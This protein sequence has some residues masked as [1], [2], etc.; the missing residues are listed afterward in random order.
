[1]RDEERAMQQFRFSEPASE[2]LK[3]NWRIYNGIYLIES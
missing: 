1:M 3:N 2:A